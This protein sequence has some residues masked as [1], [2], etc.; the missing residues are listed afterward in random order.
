MLLFCAGLDPETQYT[1]QAE[2]LVGTGNDQVASD[3][4]PVMGQTCK[5]CINY[6]V[7]A[8]SSRQIKILEVGAFLKNYSLL[9]ESVMLVR[10]LRSFLF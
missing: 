2:T 9:Q 5:C 3:P 6:I 1:I 7:C 8:L 4:V 10:L